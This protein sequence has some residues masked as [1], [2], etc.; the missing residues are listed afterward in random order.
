M[1][2]KVTQTTK[3][4]NVAL[5]P[6]GTTSPMPCTLRRPTVGPTGYTNFLEVKNELTYHAGTHTKHTVE[7]KG[8]TNTNSL[9]VNPTLPMANDRGTLN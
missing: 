3:V 6:T 7:D 5:L 9:E 1:K 2:G 4:L 8:E